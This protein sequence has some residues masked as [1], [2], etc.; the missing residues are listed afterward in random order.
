MGVMV[1]REWDFENNEFEVCFKA[2]NM[3]KA[4]EISHILMKYNFI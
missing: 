4:S 1:N 3:F 2:Q